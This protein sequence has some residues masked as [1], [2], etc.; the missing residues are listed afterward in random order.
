MKSPNQLPE[1]N[2]PMGLAMADG[3]GPLDAAFSFE[4]VA[5]RVARG[6]S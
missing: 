5:T 4:A 3:A 2:A 1:H 6:S